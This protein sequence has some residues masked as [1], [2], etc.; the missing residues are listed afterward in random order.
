[1][2]EGFTLLFEAWLIESCKAM[3]VNNVSQ[4][5]GVSNH[6]IW[7]VLETIKQELLRHEDFSQIDTR[8]R[9]ETSV[10]FRHNYI[11][12]FVDLKEKKTLYHSDGKG[13]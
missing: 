6:K 4:L 2:F 5:T 7:Y 12:L 1:V 3:P 9:D 10:A 8:V 13:H 11:T